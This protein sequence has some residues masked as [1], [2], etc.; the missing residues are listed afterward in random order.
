[1]SKSA[2]QLRRE[3]T[4]LSIT[5]CARELT[6]EHG[7]DGFT[8]DQLAERA[9]VSRRTLFNYVPGKIDAV[10]GPEHE[11]DPALWEAFLAGGPTGRLLVDV[12][13]ILRATLAADAPDPAE[14]D[15]VRRVLHSDPR[16]IT[17]VH[18]RF[19]EKSR[20]LS[21]AITRR[22]GQ[23]LDPLVMRLLSAS[24]VAMCD[25][26]L[27]EALATP[28][29]TVAECLDLTFDAMSSLFEPPRD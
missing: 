2:T 3:R 14:V 6:Q 21:E 12:L 11:I 27:D 16:L 5:R 19:V 7:L 23:A 22:E 28:T 24:V 25:A 1:M 13:E 18:E 9:G 10:L 26:A 29:R 4:L 17:A 15:A 8:M 20:V